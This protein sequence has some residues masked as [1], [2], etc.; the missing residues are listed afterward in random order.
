MAPPKNFMILLV[1]TSLFLLLFLTPSV[2]AFVW[3]RPAGSTGGN[4]TNLSQMRDVNIPTPGNGEVLTWNAATARWISSSAGAG[5]TD[6]WRLNYTKYYNKSQ[7][8][9]NFSKYF[10]ITQILS[11]NYNSTF[12][13]TYN[14][15]VSLNQ[16]NNSLFLGGFNWTTNPYFDRWALDTNATTECNDGEYL[17]GDGNCYPITTSKTYNASSIVLEQGVHDGGD[18]ASIQFVDDGDTY[19]ISEEGGI[20]SLRVNITFCDVE[21]IDFIAIHYWYDD[22]DHSLPIGLWDFVNGG[23]EFE[24]GSM[25]STPTFHWYSHAVLD[26]DTHINASGCAILQI[27]HDGTGI[28]W[29]DL[30]LD[31]VFLQKGNQL[32]TVNSIFQLNDRD[33]PTAF[34][35]AWDKNGSKNATGNWNLGDYNLTNISWIFPEK[36]NWT[37]NHVNE[38][39][40]SFENFILTIKESWLYSL[41]YTKDEVYN[42][43]ETYNK[44]EIDNNFSLYY[45][46]TETDNNFSL[47]YTKSEVYNI[48]ET[49]NKSEIDNNLSNYILT[50]SESNL[51]VNS[52]LSL[53]TS[54]GY[55][56]DVN[57][58][59]FDLV[60]YILTI[61]LSQLTSYIDNWFTTKTTDDLTEG[62]TNKYNN[63]SWNESRSLKIH[64]TKT[65]SNNNLN[66]NISAINTTSNIESL[67]FVQ[68]EHTVNG[69]SIN[70]T[71][72]E[73][74]NITITDTLCFNLDCSSKIF[75]TGSGSLKV[76]VG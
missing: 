2:E 61:D 48:T 66:N 46:K 57:S 75:E 55:V 76:V 20:N 67:G 5:Q 34:D 47:Y 37:Y 16:S 7:V 45:T 59:W 54:I 63:Q 31:A 13:Q 10:T 15:Y 44:S 70:V 29:H 49:Y 72:I 14:N 53:N 39:Q 62:S 38:T 11:F 52:S 69:T 9:N 40:F 58:T 27:D 73:T 21:D 68:G 51:N 23:F 36:I 33:D 65:E 50:S 26:A 6:T 64:Y 30:Y 35:W 42:T 18:I 41:F 19:N 12:N 3:N 60:G 56:K 32:T 8:D 74:K 43:S 17:D 4:L 71:T 1:F 25:P 22:G 28:S 24:Y